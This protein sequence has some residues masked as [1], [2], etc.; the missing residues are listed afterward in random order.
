M[1]MDEETGKM[2]A[3]AM[4][5]VPLSL[6]VRKVA[7]QPQFKYGMGARQTPGGGSILFWIAPNKES[8]QAFLQGGPDGPLGS[9]G[10]VV[11][12]VGGEKVTFRVDEQEEGVK[13]S[14]GKT[15]WSAEVAQFL[16][17]AV[18]DKR[19]A[20]GQLKWVN[21]PEPNATEPKADKNPAVR[22][23]LY[24]GDEDAGELFLMS[25]LPEINIQQY[26]RK[27]FGDYWF[28]HGEKT[29]RE[30]M[31]GQGGSRIDIVQGK[32]DGQ[33]KLFYRYWNRKTLVA[34][35]ELDAKGNKDNA[36]NAF[37]MPMGQLKMYA[38]DFV[39]ADLPEK[40]TLPL[41]FDRSKGISQRTPAAK[42]KLTVDDQEK[43]FWIN[44]YM[45]DPG[46]A[47][48]SNRHVVATTGT[49]R[50][51]SLTMPVNAVD[52]GFRIYLHDFERKL[53]PGTSQPSHYSSVVDFRDLRGDRMVHREQSGKGED[54][55][56][57]NLPER[58]ASVVDAAGEW[59]YWGDA[60][61]R[62]ILRRQVV[63]AETKSSHFDDIA[64]P[65]II[66]T[67]SGQPVAITLDEKAGRIYWAET[68]VRSQHQRMA[69][70]SAKIR[71]V[72]IDGTD[73]Q[74]VLSV[75]GTPLALTL[76][77]ESQRI[78]WSARLPR[79]RANDD[80]PAA[81]RLGVI[82]SVG[83]DGQDA[84][85]GLLEKLSYPSA[86]ALDPAAE[87]IYWSDPVEGVIRHAGWDGSDSG[88]ISLQD[89]SYKPTSLA[90]HSKSGRVFW[91]D[92]I[93]PEHTREA[94]DQVKAHRV[95]SAKL[96]GSD[97]V[98]VALE[99]VYHPSALQ[100]AAD[101][102]V[103]W[104]QDAT[105]QSKVWIPMN[106]PVEF[107]DRRFGTSYRLFQ[108]SFGGPWKPGSPLYEE[109]VPDHVSPDSVYMSVL[110]VNHDPGRGIRGV[111]L[112]LIVV[113][114]SVMFYMRA[115]FYTP[116]PGS[117][118]SEAVNT[119]VDATPAEQSVSKV[120]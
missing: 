56:I 7:G 107:S 37:K 81:T 59:V 90:I 112:G 118:K 34:S 104:T 98:A 4:S 106:A 113:G 72:K 76:D 69:A 35:G 115:Y 65:E 86:L 21:A 93:E 99:R 74:D 47:P 33:T 75:D 55:V 12:H 103:M 31:Q 40:V 3:S 23:K 110:T 18:P 120:S 24:E 45:Q 68:S 13:F 62:Q 42:V 88:S 14:L 83:F 102:T 85:T 114:I 19:G 108:E 25:D 49:D 48:T 22:I 95:M 70:T 63:T 119:P 52:V 80:Q 20:D 54:F 32:Q 111:G 94:G 39:S 60:K 61:T 17:T 84:Q 79:V 50:N 38:A 57:P 100:L 82:G 1:K 26:D 116:I 73:R 67:T 15:G 41:P 8:T 51:V 105:Y 53:D 27:V 46:R 30:L 87:K 89:G 92:W 66:A 10:Q 9:K 11:L 71:S 36:V 44:A 91:T 43:E 28:D 96:D 77:V 97:V 101:G 6:N 16:E 64:R 5:W 29:A 117:K 2:K 58:A 78:F 109:I